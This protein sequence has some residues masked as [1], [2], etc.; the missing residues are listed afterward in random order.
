MLP[1]SAPLT[2]RRPR[3]KRLDANCADVRPSTRAPFKPDIVME[4]GNLGRSSPGATPMELPELMLLTTS[5]EFATGQTPFRTMGETSAAT[6]LAANLA[7]RLAPLYPDFMPETLRGMLVHSARWTSAII[8]RSKNAQG[9]SDSNRLLRTFGYGAP[10]VEELFSSAK[11][12]LTLIAQD[13]IQPFLKEGS[14]VKTN[15]I[16]HHALPWPAD[17]LRNLPLGTEVE[18]RVTLSY[19]VKPSPGERGW[20]KKYGYGSHGLRFAVMRA[21]ETP[22]QTTDI[23]TPVANLIGVPVEIST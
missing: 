5:N 8:Q 15:G 12:S 3:P 10:D 14:A 7:A 21:T 13:S 20:D 4:A 17:V 9:F 6:A 22:D 2:V 1:L 18:M 19:F 11:N 23:Y 16:K